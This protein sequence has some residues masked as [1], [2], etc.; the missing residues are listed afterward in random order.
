M[1]SSSSI[2]STSIKNNSDEYL[3]MDKNINI[4]IKTKIN[5]NKINK[6]DEIKIKKYIKKIIEEM[7]SGS[8]DYISHYIFI[9]KI[10]L[11]ENN[12]KLSI[13]MILYLDKNGKKTKVH[14]G[15]K[16]TKEKLKEE[17]TKKKLR[18]HILW[19]LNESSY[20][21]DP[22]KL[23]EFNFILPENKIMDIII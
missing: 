4:I 9:K 15:K 11:E 23:S 20:R 12:K 22:L 14:S 21:S 18:D 5:S 1:G 2:E 3:D 17:C 6:K 8:L 7:S 10:F 16:L 13:K 19:S